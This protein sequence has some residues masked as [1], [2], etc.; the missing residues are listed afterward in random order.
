M[1]NLQR[2]LDQFIEIH[3]ND[4]NIRSTYNNDNIETKTRSSS[5]TKDDI[6]NIYTTSIKIRNHNDHSNNDKSSNINSKNIDNSVIEN[7]T[8]INSTFDSIGV[9]NTINSIVNNTDNNIANL[10]INS[11]NNENNNKIRESNNTNNT[12]ISNNNYL[13]ST[14]GTSNTDNSHGNSTSN[15]KNSYNSS[16]RIITNNSNIQKHF[17]VVF[18]WEDIEFKLLNVYNVEYFKGFEY[19]VEHALYRASICIANKHQL[20]EICKELLSIEEGEEIHKKGE[21]SSVSSPQAK[22][23]NEFRKSMRELNLEVIDFSNDGEFK[24]WKH[25][26][27]RISRELYYGEEVFWKTMDLIN[28]MQALRSYYLL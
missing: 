17:N 2:I 18:S 1:E 25:I 19:L 15:T 27:I 11:V 16:T 20:E 24:Y 3:N 13:K 4:N 6:K 21:T 22:R 9:K 8:H 12:S 14:S 23:R 7:T 5:I 28:Q 10:D 26:E